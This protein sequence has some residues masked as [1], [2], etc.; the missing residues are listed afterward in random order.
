MDN[1]KINEVYTNVNTCS[2]FPNAFPFLEEE[3]L[4]WLKAN[5]SFEKPHFR[6]MITEMENWFKLSFSTVF[7]ESQG[8]LWAVI[9]F[10]S[11]SFAGL[12]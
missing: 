12:L 1:R 2:S 4:A 3:S 10:F 11:V 5:R 7:S 9:L 6:L 8:L